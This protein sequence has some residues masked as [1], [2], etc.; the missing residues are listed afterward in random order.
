[1]NR[2]G[3]V[4]RRALVVAAFVGPVL[5]AGCGIGGSG[6]TP[7]EVVQQSYAK[8]VAAGTAR[9]QFQ[10]S[11]SGATQ[12]AITGNGE[13]DL[14]HQGFDMSTT[15]QGLAQPLRTV[16][17]GSHSYLN[18]PIL[19]SRIPG[20]KPWLLIDPERLRQSSNPVA[21]Q[22]ADT[23]QSPIS[24]FAI[25]QGAG[26]DTRVVGSEQV[27][28]AEATHY[29]STLDLNKAVGSTPDPAAKA[30]LKAY[31]AKIGWT[32]PA[33]LWIDKQGRLAKLVLRNIHAGGA[34]GGPSASVSLTFSGF[35]QPVSISAPPADQTGDATDLINQPGH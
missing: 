3:R 18:M 35:G 29:T 17:T 28:G 24:Q 8:T 26:A 21:Q 19:T 33:D 25:V 4:K 6:S 12:A 27:N 14:A 11:V 1:M 10:A 15:V 20:G 30:S 13:L 7:Q 22:L 23:A 9:V 32:V 5:L 31:A 2:D 16:G 34:T